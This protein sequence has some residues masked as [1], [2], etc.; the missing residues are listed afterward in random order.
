[1]AE[2]IAAVEPRVYVADRT[3]ELMSTRTLLNELGIGWSELTADVDGCIDLLISTPQHA[4]SS[5]H[6]EGR[7]SARAHIVIGQGISRTLRKELARHP[8]D[9]V[10][11]TPVHPA[12]LR[13]LIEHSIYRGP[14]RRHGMRAVI[15]D[16]VKVKAG[17]WSK[18]A[19][20]MQLSE[21]GAGLVLDQPVTPT[22]LTLRMPTAWT[23]GT[24]L[25]LKA[26]VLEQHASG[27]GDHVVSVGFVGLD[28]AKRRRLRDVMKVRA[29]HGGMLRPGG[30]ADDG[31]GAAE[32]LAAG[33]RESA[34]EQRAATGHRGAAQDE[35]RPAGTATSAPAER[36]GGD[37]RRETTRKVFTRRVLATLRG[38]AQAVVS[39]DI[40]AGGMRLA[41]DPEIHQGDELKL[42]LYGAKGSPP[43][44][45]RAEVVRSNPSEG[46]GIKFLNV[47]PRMQE[48]LET[49]LSQSPI[50][51][52]VAGRDKN[53]KNDKGAK[54]QG[55]EAPER[56]KVVVTE[57]LDRIEGGGS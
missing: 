39:R 47:P 24:K 40:S 20:L 2:A 17:F 6:T 15:E 32:S 41:P 22:E 9:Y 29:S 12:A 54:G 34:D 1:M 19:T 35:A 49:L 14:E 23:G 18:K 42:A 44:V 46:V 43:L 5:S 36:S 51:G 13:A 4:L 55:G 38:Q 7:V 37:D 33:A 10:V 3:G 31:T 48:R 45:L 8:C 11:E 21:R 50:L 52:S 28:G 25:E 57:I 27:D 26:R 53:D 30:P 16:E 56:P